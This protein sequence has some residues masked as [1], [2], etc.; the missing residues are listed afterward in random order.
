MGNVHIGRRTFLKES[1]GLVTGFAAIEAFAA[2]KA[3]KKPA[4][5]SDWN[6][7]FNG[8][9]LNGWKPVGGA[10]WK[11]EDHCI[12]GTQGPNGVAGDL[13]TEKEFGDFELRATIKIHWP[14]NSGIWFRYTNPDSAYQAD[15]LEYKDPEAYSGSLYCP[16][17]MFIAINK[18]KSIEKHDDW[19]TYLVS[20]KG[21]HLVITLNGKVTADVHDKSFTR[22]AIGFQVHPGNEFKDMKVTVRDVAIRV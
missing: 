19:N 14:A 10:I 18:D 13:F 12:V 6:S 11:V 15:I 5:K 8:K 2:E 17:K 3:A 1:A 7:L 4:A 21:D 20:A 22:G 16:G 9:D